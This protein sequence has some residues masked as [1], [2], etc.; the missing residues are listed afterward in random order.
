MPSPLIRTLRRS[1]STSPAN[2]GP[3]ARDEAARARPLAPASAGSQH[4][5]LVSRGGPSRDGLLKRLLAFAD[6]IAALLA[7]AALGSTVHQ[8]LATI[9][10]AATSVPL[11]LLLAKLHGL[12]DR[13]ERVLHHL[14]VDELPSIAAWAVTG[15]A[16]T[17][18]VL[19]LSPA[20]IPR[21]SA[22]VIAT[23]VAGLAG[24][25][26][27]AAARSLWRAT[28]P[29]E[30]AMIVGS[31]G[32]ARA[33]RR[34]VDLFPDMHVRIVRA[35]EESSLE[36]LSE[37]QDHLLPAEASSA[38]VERV[39]LATETIDEALIAELVA[40]CRRRNLKL[41]VVPPVRGMFGTA[42]RLSHVAD[43]PLVEYNTW[44]VARSTLLL[45]R[46]LDLV[47][48][49]PLLVAA[50]PLLA[51]VAIAIRLDTSGSALFLQRRAGLGGRD[52]R[53]FK[54]RTMLCDAERRLEEIGV[55]FEALSDPMFKLPDDPRV[56]RLG[57]FLRRMSL[58][59]LPQLINVVKGDMSMVGPRPEELGIVRLY[60]PEE[61][62][63]LSVKPGLTGPMQVY[64]R[65]NLQWDERLAVER[66]YVENLS[67]GRDVRI[68]ALT[69]A[70]VLRGRGAY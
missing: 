1:P 7:A 30:G 19:T 32:L 29:P 5:P 46:A 4:L 21:L 26:L 22:I 14:T 67:I 62:F 68:L 10:W 41:S 63:R 39:I 58:D 64:G 28:T 13:D 51:V 18:A 52:F 8:P 53:M 45:K 2:G 60:A 61:R 50:L 34:K 56:T 27:R 43:L 37:E 65:G 38:P 24:V 23:A 42:V 33:T 15:V 48:G 47:L 69:A 66:E 44:E 11:W 12:Y 16:G 49:V 3:T 25:L 9:F 57:K 35:V 20:P 54:F 70:T 40:R 6:G 55:D 59:E 17:V 36:R 31:D